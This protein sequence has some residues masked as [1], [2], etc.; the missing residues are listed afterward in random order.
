MTENCDCIKE[1]RCTCQRT[2][3]L[4]Y[5]KG[6][7]IHP[8]AETVFINARKKLPQI[9]L[10][11]VYRN[12]QFLVDK[13]KIIEL[14]TEPKRYDGVTDKH[15]HYVCKRCDTV[16]D[17]INIRSNLDNLKYIPRVGS[18]DSYQIYLTGICNKCKKKK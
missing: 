8:T 7:R 1:E 13:G 17:I 4:D 18:V 16:Y 10:G 14:S 3:I 15:V 5:I 2:V 12:I 6:V 9:S 11:T